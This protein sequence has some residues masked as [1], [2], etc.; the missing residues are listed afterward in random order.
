LAT[1]PNAERPRPASFSGFGNLNVPGTRA[2]AV[3]SI[4]LVVLAWLTIPVAQPFL[5]GTA[6]VGGILGAILWWKHSRT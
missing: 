5:L 4:G 3:I 2:G 6:G 1:P